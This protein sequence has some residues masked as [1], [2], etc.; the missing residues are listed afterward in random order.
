M[1][2]DKHHI[3]MWKKVYQMLIIT[4][5]WNHA[6]DKCETGAKLRRGDKSYVI[7]HPGGVSNEWAPT[8]RL[9]SCSL[10]YE[11]RRRKFIH[12]SH[13]LHNLL[14]GDKNR[15]LVFSV[16]YVASSARLHRPFFFFFALPSVCKTF[17]YVLLYSPLICP[18]INNYWECFSDIIH[19]T[20]HAYQC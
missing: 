4:K 11:W 7:Y 9:A 8:P 18:L 20:V 6:E 12:V 15:L 5:A 3:S 17:P 10:V 13:C 2:H 1:S 16:L 14:T 19:E